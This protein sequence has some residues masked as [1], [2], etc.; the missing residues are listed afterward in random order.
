MKKLLIVA[1]VAAMAV[2][3]AL[4]AAAAELD[5][6][7]KLSVY[8]EL[9]QYDFN[10][11]FFNDIVTNMGLYLK[12]T[13]GDLM[14][15]SIP[16]DITLDYI[17]G[18]HTHEWALDV[19]L[20]DR[21]YDPAYF[22]FKGTPLAFSFSNAKTGDYAMK[23]L[24]DPLGLFYETVRYPDYTVKTW[25]KLFGVDV[26]GYA[27]RVWDDKKWVDD[28]TAGYGYAWMSGKY[29]LPSQH[30]LSAYVGTRARVDASGNY[31][32]EEGIQVSNLELVLN[33][34]IQ[35][36]GGTFT[37][38]G[39]VSLDKWNQGTN[40]WYEDTTDYAQA[41]TVSGYAFK[42]A[43]D[44]VPFG[45]FTVDAAFSGVDPNFEAVGPDYYSDGTLLFSKNYKKLSVTATTP[46]DLAGKK[47]A[48]T[49][50]DTYK[51]YWN[52]DP[53]YNEATAKA[54]F[55]V[56]PKVNMTLSGKL[57]TDLV[58]NSTGD[59]GR[60]FSAEAA[61]SP[62]ENLEV[63]GSY[64]WNEY[65]K[66]YYSD[67][68]SDQALT[69]NF[70]FSVSATPIEGVTVEGSANYGFDTETA[71]EYTDVMGYG[72]V[73]KSFEPGT[74]KAVNT[75]VAGLAT[76]DGAN[77]AAWGY[78]MGEIAFNDKVTVKGEVLSADEKD[79]PVFT[80]KLT[81]AASDNTTFTA[82][83]THRTYNAEPETYYYAEIAQKLGVSTLKLTWGVSGLGDAD[84]YFYNN[85]TSIH[86]GRLWSHL[87]PTAAGAM[88]TG[89]FTLSIEIPF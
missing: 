85:P 65:D 35:N 75:T 23:G 51:A 43:V 41:E 6:S 26:L 9:D 5:V 87:Y 17:T 53:D 68:P 28:F 57:R 63:S 12:F 64:T 79:A 50:G 7:G 71:R 66:Y 73:V 44:D 60:T 4:P 18:G 89:L 52:G 69:H 42:A 34:P 61:Y 82:I 21:Y 88:D 20:K 1:I 32:S 54:E 72:E 47:I 2:A 81:Y 76:Y 86:K 30:V 33:G 8:W 45:P 38:A 13:E 49:L 27:A 15:A 14:E 29:T 24:G 80:G 19:D 70:A 10:T 16:L 31:E 48:L 25:G 3:F 58:E 55:E 84:T 40:K 39:A 36:Y 74:V 83:S 59:D 78:G 37:L 11:R 22:V 62:D 77:A 46:F 56:A 67:T